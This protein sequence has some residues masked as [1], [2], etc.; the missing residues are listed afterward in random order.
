MQ[1]PTLRRAF[2]F[3]IDYLAAVPPR[4]QANLVIEQVTW[5]QAIKS[6]DDLAGI[7]VSMRYDRHFWRSQR[8]PRPHL[9]PRAFAVHKRN[10]ARP[11]I[12]DARTGA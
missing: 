10:H 3:V 2:S 7:E 6:G 9:T 12:D 8:R 5:M 11:G 1:S 4:W